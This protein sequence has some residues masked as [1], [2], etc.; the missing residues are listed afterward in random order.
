MKE[1]VF[2]THTHLKLGDRAW[3][4]RS[5][6]RS[7]RGAQETEEARRKHEQE[8]FLWLL[9]EKQSAGASSGVARLKIWGG[10]WVIG[11]VPS[12]PVPG[13]GVIRAGSQ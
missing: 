9:P 6:W 2:H 3:L 4:C 8:P 5:T 13:P 7:T 1:E 10:L 11:T 12:C